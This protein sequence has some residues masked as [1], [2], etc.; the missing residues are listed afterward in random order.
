MVC[1]CVGGGG[2]S[3][4]PSKD[5]IVSAFGWQH[6]STNAKLTVQGPVQFYHR[7][8][9]EEFSEQYDDVNVNTDIKGPLR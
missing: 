7:H 2:W 1:V 8:I 6:N 3:F 4:P 9:S 5:S